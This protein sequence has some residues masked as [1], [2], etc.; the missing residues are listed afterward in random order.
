[1]EDRKKIVIG[2]M[3][4]SIFVFIVG[5]SSLYVQ[6]QIETGNACGCLIPI[7]L[8]I[9]FLASVGLLIGTMVYYLLTPKAV[10]RTMDREVIL[11]LFD[12][13]ERKIVGFL[14]NNKGEGVQSRMVSETDMSKVKV[15]RV[16]ERLL[17]KGIIS[18]DPHGKTNRILLN[19]ELRNSIE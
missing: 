14:L 16:L 17:K 10:Y 6:T 11:R 3:I 9:P 18:K 13:D 4:I 7:T 8:F 2:V 1:M 5:V 19:E 15:F 12:Q